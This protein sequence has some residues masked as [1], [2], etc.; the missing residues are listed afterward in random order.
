[1]R[2]R[3][4]LLTPKNCRFV[5]RFSTRSLASR[6]LSYVPAFLVA[7]P[8]RHPMAEIEAPLSIEKIETAVLVLDVHG[9]IKCANASAL[10]LLGRAKKEL[11]GTSYANFLTLA[12]VAEREE[13]LQD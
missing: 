8:E 6:R 2:P 3:G 7:Q 1:M 5:A 12:H 9:R 13:R 11:L 10:S 4:A